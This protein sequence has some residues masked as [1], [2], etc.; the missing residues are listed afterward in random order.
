[1]KPIKKQSAIAYIL[2]ALIPYSSQSIMLGFK[3]NQFFN[4]L[5]KISR[6]N[7][8]A[9][10]EA[11]R[12]AERRGLIQQNKEKYLQLTELGKRQAL[13]FIAKKLTDSQMMVIFDIPEDGPRRQ[14]R[15]LLRSW[16]FMLVQKS[17]WISKYDHRESVA[18]A[19]DT[20][21]LE[22]FVRVYECSPMPPD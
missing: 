21:N 2:K 19:I 16:D 8:R 6:Y 17:V 15:Q 11:A 7:R 3:P 22:G 18:T 13:P 10:E 1:M 5:E 20:L 9:L 14:F 4:E 12:R